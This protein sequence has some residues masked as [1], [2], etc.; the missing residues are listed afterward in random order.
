MHK[1]LLVALRQLNIGEKICTLA[2]W[3]GINY[4]T[5]DKI[6]QRVLTTIYFSHL[7]VMNICWLFDL[8]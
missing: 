1:Q 4:S 2:M 3:A 5:V 7:T 8:K 6:T